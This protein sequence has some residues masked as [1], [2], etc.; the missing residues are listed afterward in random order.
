MK[1]WVQARALDSSVMNV[2]Y[3]LI[4]KSSESKFM[5]ECENFTRRYCPVRYATF[6][7]SGHTNRIVTGP[8]NLHYRWDGLLLQ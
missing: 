2:H 3:N 7:K 8:D 4:V 6:L 5:S 1:G